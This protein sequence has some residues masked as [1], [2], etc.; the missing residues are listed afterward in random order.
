LEFTGRADDQVKIRGIRIEPGEIEA[1][2]RRHDLVADAVVVAH[3]D[4][5]GVRRLVAYVVCTAEAPVTELREFLGR[6]L[7]EHL[8]PAAFVCLDALPLN[9]SG[10]LNR[11]ALPAPEFGAAQ[12]DHV[13]PRTPTE[14]VLATVWAEV[15][16]LPRVGVHDNFFEL[17]GDSILSIQVVSRAR[18]HGLR[19][20][21]KDL[22]LHQTIATLAG[23]VTVA[24]DA[25]ADAPTVGDV[26]LTP[27]QQWFFDT[28]T[29]RPAH[30]NQSVLVEVPSD[31]DETALA[32][33]LAD[34]MAH[35]D[36]LRMRFERTED[37]WRQYNPPV[38][39][40]EVL[41]HNDTDDIVEIE[42][43][44]D[45]L[46]A[47]FDL[48]AG[49]LFKAML[50]GGHRETR[51]LFL[52]AHHLVCDGVSW[53]I[54]LADLAQA[55]RQAAAGEPV[56][57]GTRT[58]SFRDWAIRLAEHTANG[59]FDDELDHWTS[60]RT[61][62]LPVDHVDQQPIPK[63][64]VVVQLDAEDTEALLRA[65]PAAYRARINDV[66]LTAVACAVTRWTGAR[67]VSVDLEGHGREEMFD[68]VDVSRT[69]GWF[70]TVYPVTLE[71][72]DDR[73]WRQTVQAVRRQLRAVPNNGLGFGALRHLARPT[74]LSTRDAPI[75]FN[76]LGQWDGAAGGAEDGLFRAVHS[77]I[78]R[79]HDPATPDTHLLEVVGGVQDGQLTF[80]WSYRPD[81]HDESTVR[82][83]AD[84]FASALRAIA[85]DCR[86]PR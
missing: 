25:V 7:P 82:A 50:F 65:A 18:Q 57:L 9:P 83:V 4:P 5:P 29:A 36:A 24:Q 80:S 14:T 46:H 86:R 62:D 3:E 8:V 52:V 78:G 53:R 45:E 23:Q 12:Q 74:Q 76:Y 28:H 13:A 73:P 27:V 70:T 44:A 43:I 67:G 41:H 63:A 54:V 72:P 58:T 17:G 81:R 30:F 61:V 1:A 68:D 47:G 33:A 34:L 40:L 22:F 10:K 42:R 71:L 21:S 60:V 75:A 59:G 20:K 56:D 55:Y 32:T 79:E 84:D 2:L 19:L 49:P 64:D 11:A 15:L 69:I 39:P 31:V 85:A 6:R 66:L 26:P 37:G 51:Y 38:Q 16:G 35:H 48:A 77:A